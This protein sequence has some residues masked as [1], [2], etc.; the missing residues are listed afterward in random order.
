MNLN[1]YQEQA[2]KTAIYP[3]EFKIIYPT[4][5]LAGETGEIAEKIKK[6]IRDESINSI[7]QDKLQDLKKEL[8]DVLWYIAVLATDLNLNLNDI[9]QTNLDKLQSRQQRN[10]LSGSGD[11]R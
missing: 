10:K 1:H 2:I 6:I 8:G 5:G 4:I 9:A 3:N 7:S 11:N